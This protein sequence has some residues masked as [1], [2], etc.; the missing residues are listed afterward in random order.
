[1]LIVSFV[2]DI[3]TCSRVRKVSY[4]DVLYAL[5]LTGSVVNLE[6]QKDI[7]DKVLELLR[8]TDGREDRV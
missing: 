4:T 3:Q 5:F 6:R 8:E 1:M 2:V 7:H